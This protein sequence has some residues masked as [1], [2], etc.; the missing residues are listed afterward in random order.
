MKSSNEKTD[1][2]E[3]SAVRKQIK[4]LLSDFYPTSPQYRA[5]TQADKRISKRTK[6]MN[7]ILTALHESTP[8]IEEFP[9]RFRLVTLANRYLFYVET[10]GN[11]YVNIALLLLVGRGHALHL[12]PDY[13]HRYVRHATTL[14]DIESPT[15]SLAVKLDFLESH[16]LSFFK[17][18]IDTTLRNRI[19]HADFTINDDG[20][21]SYAD[22]KGRKKSTDLRK[23]MSCF[24]DYLK[25][26]S[27]AF[28]EE[29]RTSLSQDKLS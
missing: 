23:E 15:L 22:A 21:L 5:Y 18:W 13:K 10:F 11:F 3:I 28:L 16:K 4:S 12:M 8:L 17:K 25:A 2:E 14:E 24:E 29:V 20:S 1:S 27:K 6:R 7:S 26:I 19:A 9:P